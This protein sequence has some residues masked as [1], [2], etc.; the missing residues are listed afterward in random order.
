M[1]DA[2]NLAH[3]IL[4]GIEAPHASPAATMPGFAGAL[5]DQQVVLLMTYL[6]KTFSNKQPWQ[7]L[8][9]TVRNVRGPSPASKRATGRCSGGN[10]VSLKINGRKHE[11]GAD[12]ATPLLYVLRD[13]LALN[14]AKF[15]CGHGQCGA[16]T[17]LIDDKPALSCITPIAV[18]ESRRITT[19]E[20]LGGAEGPGALQQAFIAEQAAQCGYCIAGMVMRAEALLRKNPQPSE[21][22]IR[23]HMQPNL[24]RCGTHMR[25]LAAIRRVALALACTW[26]E[27]KTLSKQRN[28]FNWVRSTPSEEH[29]IHDIS[30]SEVRQTSQSLE[31]TYRRLF[32]NAWVDRSVLRGGQDRVG[33]L[34]RLDAC[35]RG[36]SA[37]RCAFRDAALPGRKGPLHPHGGFRLLRTQRGR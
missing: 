37:A 14:G 3:V 32:S 6:R 1:P 19:I 2:R 17:A 8:G 29:V 5:T 13:E 10:M 35:S 25:I 15:G 11:V 18:T 34:D 7:G 12:G 33:H 22:Q 26:Q 30:S 31:A 23:A 4:E 27:T 28:I 36:L 20:G 21:A 16:C 9:N 24:C